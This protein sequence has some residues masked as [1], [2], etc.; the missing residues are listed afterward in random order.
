MIML[1][2]VL[3]DS[4]EFPYPVL[5]LTLDNVGRVQE[6]VAVIIRF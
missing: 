1:G 5:P 6:A 3:V 2:E 4:V